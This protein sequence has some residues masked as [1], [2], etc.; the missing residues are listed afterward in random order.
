MPEKAATRLQAN[1][2]GLLIRLPD[3]LVV[4]VG[5]LEQVPLGQC[6]RLLQCK[7]VA[8]PLSLSRLG[9]R[10]SGK[11]IPQVVEKFESG[12]KPKELLERVVMRP[13]QV[14]R[15]GSACSIAAMACPTRIE[16]RYSH[17]TSAGEPDRPV[18]RGS[19]LNVPPVVYCG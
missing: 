1:G 13:R 3:H 8:K 9:L 2:K 5:H 12:V 10:L 6:S 7:T 11:K 15:Q 16:H 17:E 4:S 19:K 14:N 18:H